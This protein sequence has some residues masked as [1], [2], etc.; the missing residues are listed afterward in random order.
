MGRILVA[1]P[2]AQPALDLLAESHETD[3]RLGLPRDQLLQLLG[4]VGGWDAL[5]VRSQTRVDGDLLAAAAP[6]LS[7][8]GVASV[9]IDRIDVEA[10]TRAGVMI[11]NAPTGNTVAA[12]EH[13]M[14]MMLALLRHI[15]DADSSV[16]GGAWDRARYTGRELR[17]KVLGVIGLGKI[18]KAVARRA[19]G[20]EMR[21]IA[22]DPY[23]TEEQAGEAGARLVGLA[24][25]LH[26]SDVITVH[27]PLTPQTRGL[28]GRA[29]LEATKPG[30]FVLNVARG[31]IVDERALADAL[32]SGHL[33][34]AA[35]DVYSAEPMTADNPLRSAPNVVLTPHLGASTAEAQDRVGLE[36]AEQ[37]LMALAGVTPP[38]ALNAPALAPETAP[39]VRPYVELGRRLAIL[40]RQL[41]P[42]A[43]DALSLTYAGEIAGGECAPIRTAALAGLL[44][45]VTDQRVNA[46]NADLVARE[47]GLTVREERTPSS[48]PWASLVEIAVGPADGEPIL[49]LAGST[50][51]GHQHLAGV[52]GFAIDAE[53]AGTV[54][55]TRHHDRPGIVG[56]VGTILAEAGINISSLELSRLSEHG[57]A[58]MFISVDEAIEDAILDRIR[59]AD[60]IVEVRL[61]QLPSR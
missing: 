42:S 21:V 28:L 10:A 34:G 14:A 8:V 46:V 61:V 17:G 37:V 1:E 57:Q 30:A 40:A 7:V 50:A 60:G 29:Q 47:R 55:V 9:G 33:A 43:F 41:A 38:Y 16:R 3:V 52:D 35:V 48:D 31:G 53:L 26:R 32:A 11:V 22:T 4:E 56:A 44:E 19:T 27:T 24:E 51:H 39:R 15:P 6:R 54:L 20:F 5:V 13:T 25:L 23:L 49:R 58:M 18:G 2:V 45:A 59:A 36:M 12:A